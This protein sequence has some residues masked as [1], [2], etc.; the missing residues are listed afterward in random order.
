M[1]WT[2]ETVAWIRMF[3]LSHFAPSLS[4][5]L[6]ASGLASCPCL[7]LQPRIR[8]RPHPL[9]YSHRATL[10]LN[11]QLQ[12]IVRL[13]TLCRQRRCCG[14]FGV[15]GFDAHPSIPSNKRPHWLRHSR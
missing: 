12:L 2:C 8:S 10:S 4:S 5:L 7:V 11:L 1:R 13:A 15:C 6:C 3:L 14:S 9:S